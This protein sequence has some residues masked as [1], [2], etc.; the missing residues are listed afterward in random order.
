MADAELVAG[1]G[2]V[3]APVAATVVGQDPLDVIPWPA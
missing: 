3:P 1:G 2:E